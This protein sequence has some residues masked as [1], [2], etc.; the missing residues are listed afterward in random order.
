MKFSVLLPTR[1]R[2]DLLR[3]AIET[4]LRQDYENWEIIVSDNASHEDIRGFVDSLADPRV[5]YV[6]S[7]ESI[8]VT[9]NWNL[10]LFHCTGDYIIMLG[11]DD[12]LLPNYFSYARQVIEA[13]NHPEVLYTAALLYA[14]P[15]VLPDAPNGFVI[16]YEERNIFKGR[17]TPFI[18]PPKDANQYVAASLDFR[19]TFDYNMQFFLVSRSAV[20]R[21]QVHG[22]FYQSP[23]PDYYAANALLHLA[24]TILIVPKPMVIIGIS[25]KS[26]GYYYF[27]N[28]ESAGTAFLNNMRTDQT[29][30]HLDRIVLPGTDMNTCWLMAMETFAMHF[31]CRVNYSRY[32]E[33]QIRAVLSSAVRHNTKTTP[34][35]AVLH[36]NSTWY[37]RIRFFWPIFLINFLLPGRRRMKFADDL[38]ARAQSHPTSNMPALPGH[39][40]NIIQIYEWFMSNAQQPESLKA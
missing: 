24:P 27:N 33:L 30:A 4:V 22:A 21:L 19:V 20:N 28:K 36:K 17:Q 5:I 23:Y 16:S 35:L 18:L 25:P 10:A 32:R 34:T 3:F 12:G 7:E 37:E 31:K 8:P 1:N 38:M 6:R 15:G 26:F 2:L 11:D 14:Y 13:H 39:F 9:D 29:L 40:S